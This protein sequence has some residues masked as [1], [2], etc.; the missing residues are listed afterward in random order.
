MRALLIVFNQ[1]GKGT[2]WRALHFGRRLAQRG[3]CVTLMAMSQNARLWISQQEADGV[4]VI[5]TPDLLP[6]SLRSGWDAW[7]ALC[8][9]LWLRG[10][11]FDLVHAFEARPVVLLPA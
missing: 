7:D 9:V 4:R 2:Y 1:T 5:E 8:R 10:R 3:H 6:G 11:A